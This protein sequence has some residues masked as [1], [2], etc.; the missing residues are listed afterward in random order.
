MSYQIDRLSIKDEERIFGPEIEEFRCD[1]CSETF[2]I[3]ECG[4]EYED[5]FRDTIYEC[6]ACAWA[7]STREEA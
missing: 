4:R 6:K 3:A 5:R 2:P 1:G 7:N